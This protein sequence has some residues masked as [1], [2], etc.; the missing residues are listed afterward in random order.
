MAERFDERPLA[1]DSL[2]QQG[3]VELA[4]LGNRPGP[5]LLDH[6]PR[7][8]EAVGVGRTQLGPLRMTAIQFARSADRRQRRW[9]QALHVAADVDIADMGPADPDA[10]QVDVVEPGAGGTDLMEDGI[11]EIDVL[12]SRAGELALEELLGHGDASYD[13]G[14]AWAS[15]RE[16]A[17]RH[18]AT[19]TSAAV[20]GRP[21]SRRP[22]GTADGQT[23]GGAASR[24]VRWQCS[25]STYE[26]SDLMTSRLNPYISFRDNARQALEFYRTVFGGEMSVMTFGEMGMPGAPE[27]DKIMHG[28]L[29]T[30]SGYT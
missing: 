3:R 30:D 21:T 18:S 19:T 17:S 10:A 24:R 1:V 25:L 13:T 23:H 29:T 15:A 20:W 12:E 28:M 6:L 27:A 2:V 14:A 16:V 4:G 26:R 8:A 11:G 9:T 5:Q 22:P 7:L